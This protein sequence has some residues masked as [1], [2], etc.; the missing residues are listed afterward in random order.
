[1]FKRIMNFFKVYRYD[2]SDCPFAPTHIEGH[3]VLCIIGNHAI[4]G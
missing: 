1:M 2:I 4:C 3:E